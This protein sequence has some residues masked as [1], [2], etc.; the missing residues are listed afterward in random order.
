MIVIQVWYMII[1]LVDTRLLYMIHE[2]DKGKVIGSLPKYKSIY[3]KS[4]AYHRTLAA[5][6]GVREDMLL[7]GH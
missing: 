3:V 7:V 5:S 6:A 2:I 4:T 1:I